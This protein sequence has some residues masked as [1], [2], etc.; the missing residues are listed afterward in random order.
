MEV[1][2]QSMVTDRMRVYVDSSVL[3]GCFDEEF[4]DV[5]TRFFDHYFDGKFVAL[6]SDTLVEELLGSPERVQDLL[7]KV[8]TTGCERIP[9][10]E[11]AVHLRDAYMTAGVLTAKRADDALH[12]ANATIARADALVSWNFKH[13]VNPARER[14]FNGVNIASGYGI[15]SITTPEEIVRITE[16][17]PDDTEG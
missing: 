2:T 14:G 10:T 3:G 7:E 4:A 8:L 1:Q 16:A 13:L 15:I 12:V 5:T 11:A 9:A 17:S 6:I